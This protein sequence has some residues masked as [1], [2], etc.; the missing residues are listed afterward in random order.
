MLHGDGH[1]FRGRAQGFGWAHRGDSGNS[2]HEI[3]QPPIGC[4]ETSKPATLSFPLEHF[5]AYVHE[6]ARAKSISAKHARTAVQNGNETKNG[7]NQTRKKI[8][9]IL[10]V[11]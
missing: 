8:G 9:P 3:R 7:R 10:F 4:L 1:A 11:L 2:A 5:H 6:V